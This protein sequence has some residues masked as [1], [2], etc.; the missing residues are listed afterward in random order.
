MTFGPCMG[1]SSSDYGVVSSTAAAISIGFSIFELRSPLFPFSRDF[2]AIRMYFRTLYL[3]NM[4]LASVSDDVHLAIVGVLSRYSIVY[5]R[6]CVLSIFMC[7]TCTCPYV[8]VCN[9]Y[10]L[11]AYVSFLHFLYIAV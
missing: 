7:L 6:L 4:Q 9:M 3:Y 8:L 5:V 11:L 2:C 1:L 10:N